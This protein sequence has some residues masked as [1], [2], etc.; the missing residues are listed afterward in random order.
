MVSFKVS[1][2]YS[3]IHR[4]KFDPSQAVS[5][6]WDLYNARKRANPGKY[7]FGAVRESRNNTDL[8]GPVEMNVMLFE[9]SLF[10]YGML[11]DRA[12]RVGDRTERIVK[13]LEDQEDGSKVERDETVVTNVEPYALN[14]EQGVIGKYFVEDP[15]GP[16]RF[17]ELPGGLSVGNGTGYFESL[18]KNGTLNEE[19]LVG[20]T[21]QGLQERYANASCLEV[22][23]MW[24]MAMYGL[25]TRQIELYRLSSG[26][27]TVDMHMNTDAQNCMVPVVPF[28]PF[29]FVRWIAMRDSGIMWD[30]VAIL[31][32]SRT[33]EE[34]LRMRDE[35]AGMYGQAD[36]FV[37]EGVPQ[38]RL[39][40]ESKLSPQA[41][42]PE[43]F[44]EALAKTAR[45]L[46]EYQYD[47]VW[48]I[49]EKT[50]ITDTDVPLHISIGQYFQISGKRDVIMFES[51]CT[52]GFLMRR[53]VNEKL[54][55]FVWDTQERG[56]YS[57][58][59]TTDE[60]VM[61][62]FLSEFS[63]YIATVNATAVESFPH[64]DCFRDYL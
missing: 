62:G 20:F 42:A 56:K 48:Y 11:I 16:G 57:A 25:R 21:V 35:L 47:W 50:R 4:Q 19:G 7:V 10:H 54:L 27:S 36:H 64:G 1:R 23:G 55:Q 17:V 44:L 46:T 58:L 28:V 60:M 33:S 14:S 29:Q 8:F 38:I 51:E 32:S 5:A 15:S 6:I 18:L 49:P 34:F 43:T 12:G 13:V 39:S 41:N 31:S 30:S 53:R 61:S 40:M 45:M 24:S 59:H 26:N 2:S 3:Y 63:T 52:G 37:Y 22:F 9:P